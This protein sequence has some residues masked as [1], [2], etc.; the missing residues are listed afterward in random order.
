MSNVTSQ[1]YNADGVLWNK[2][3]NLE[4]AIFE[5]TGPFKQYNAPKETKDY[6]KSGYSLV[7]MLHVIGR[8]YQYGSFGIF[9]QIG[10]FFVQAT[11]SVGMPTHAQGSEESIRQLVN[12]F[13]LLKTLVLET[14][15]AMDSL[16]SSHVENMKLKTRNLE[17]SSE[18][19]DLRSFFKLNADVKLPQTYIKQSKRIQMHSSSLIP[20]E[21]DF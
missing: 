2:N 3:H 12:L 13:W 11:R 21:D 8:E 19:T 15:Q 10:V 16:R 9:K 20:Y 14:N 18:I 7:A 5:T 6:V 17:G 4:V 1:F